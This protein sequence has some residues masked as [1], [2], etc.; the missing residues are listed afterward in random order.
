MMSV[1]TT[2]D[3]ISDISLS[4]KERRSVCSDQSTIFVWWRSVLPILGL[5]GIWWCATAW[6]SIAAKHVALDTPS[7]I[8]LMTV[9]SNILGGIVWFSL[10][11]YDKEILIRLPNML[12]LATCHAVGLLASYMGLLGA[13]VSLN[14]AVKATEP[15]LAMALSFWFF[16]HVPTIGSFLAAGLVVL[17]VILVCV[18]DTTYTWISLLWVMLSSVLT[19]IRNQ[20]IKQSQNHVNQLRDMKALSPSAELWYAVPERSGFLLYVSVSA[21]ALPINVALAI[22]TM[23]DMPRAH[24]KIPNLSQDVWVSLFLAGLTHFI[25]NTAS[26]GVLSLV[27]PVTHSLAD[28][29]KRAVVVGSAAIFL[30]ESWTEKTFIGM[31]WVLLGSAIYGYLQ[32][33]GQFRG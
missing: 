18:D 19:Q 28:T 24:I 9:F 27:T 1:V 25:Y 32:K 7:A 3:S 13:R 4:R 23:C 8:P 22:L 5:V 11:L 14:Q 33:K 6:N 30:G 15:I 16:Q 21:F 10:S 2:S 26:F 29:T 20:L 17:G 31:F 12:A